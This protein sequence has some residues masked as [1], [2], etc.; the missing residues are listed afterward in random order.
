MLKHFSICAMLTL[1]GTGPLLAQQQEA[2]LRTIELPGARFHIVLAIPKS[3]AAT[4]NLDRPPEALVVSS[5]RRR[6]RADV[7]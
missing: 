7:R 6:T 3:P 5:S 4:V 1:L 2:T